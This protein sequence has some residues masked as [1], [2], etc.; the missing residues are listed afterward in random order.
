MR[1][2]ILFLFLFPICAYAWTTSMDFDGGTIGQ[3]VEGGVNGF[4]NA[5]GATVYSACPS[6]AGQCAKMQIKKGSDGWSTWGGRLLFNEHG[7]TELVKGDQLMISLD[8]F[9]PADPLI[10]GG[11]DYSAAPH[12][13][14]LRVATQSS[15]GENEGYND[16]YITPDGATHWDAENSK[17]TDAPFFYIKEQQ[18]KA[19]FI[20]SYPADR[21]QQGVWESYEVHLYFDNVTVDNGGSS[22]V[23]IRKN[24]VELAVL[25]DIQTLNTPTSK[26]T[27]FLIFTYWNGGNSLATGY[28]PVKDQYLYIDNLT[29]STESSAAKD[30]KRVVSVSSPLGFELS[31]LLMNKDG[32][33]AIVDGALFYVPVGTECG[34]P[35]QVVN[36]VT[37]TALNSALPLYLYCE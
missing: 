11:F 21:P 7:R 24:G 30:I 37:V 10:S 36:G 22:K 18:N 13:K 35:Q 34:G 5:A 27:Q 33:P 29:V 4:S 17:N 6:R 19:R 8:I 16:L 23:V 26:A 15:T 32:A 31:G 28:Y 14:F 3:K 9:F 2:I 1:Y 12:L 20:G 25:T